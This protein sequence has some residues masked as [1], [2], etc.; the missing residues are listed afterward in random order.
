MKIKRNASELINSKE[1]AMTM[2]TVANV[3]PSKGICTSQ[4]LLSSRRLKNLLGVV[5][6]WAGYSIVRRT[7]YVFMGVGTG[8][9]APQ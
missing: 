4:P 3:P 9:A 6:F 2:S 8:G 7:L 5:Y 1:Q